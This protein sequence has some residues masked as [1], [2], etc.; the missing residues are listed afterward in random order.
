MCALT[1]ASALICLAI[2]DGAA[3]EAPTWKAFR[4]PVG[5]FSVSFPGQPEYKSG[6][7]GAGVKTHAFL[8]KRELGSG[9][10]V[11]FMEIPPRLSQRLTPDAL[12]EMTTGGMLQGT[13]GKLISEKPFKHSSG[14]PC[15]QSALALQ[16]GGRVDLRSVVAPEGLYIWSVTG[17]NGFSQGPEARRFLDSFRWTGTPPEAVKVKVT[18]KPP[19]PTWKPQSPS[20]AGFKVEVPGPL[21]SSAAQESHDGQSLKEERFTAEDKGEIFQVS[22]RELHVANARDTIDAERDRFVLWNGGRLL[23][24]EPRT[25]AGVPGTEFRAELPG[26]K[27]AVVRLALAGTKLYRLEV[28]AA[29]DRVGSSTSR[30]FLESFVLTAAASASR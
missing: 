4:S 24:D 28:V 19:V 11:A 9:F 14:L 8:V 12:Q 6:S 10:L 7:Q 30:R 1:L 27:T 13:S 21:T 5:H 15:R 16:N 26:G 2:T 25:V 3:A 20:G 18:T 23:L 17:R 22:V 29:S